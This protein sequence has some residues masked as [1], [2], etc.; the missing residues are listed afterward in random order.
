MPTTSLVILASLVAVS[1][2][3]ALWLIQY[4]QHKAIERARKSVIYT[5]AMRELHQAVEQTAC[6]I[7]NK[8][9][10]FCAQQ[11]ITLSGKLNQLGVSQNKVATQALQAAQQWNDNPALLKQK[12]QTEVSESNVTAM[13]AAMKVLI[14][15]VREAA[16]R[17]ECSVPAA[18]LLIR[19]LRSS[20]LRL[21]S[22][23]YIQKGDAA[24]KLSNHRLALMHYRKLKGILVKQKSLPEELQ[25]TLKQLDDLI[26]QA[27][28]EQK[29]QT[30]NNADKRLE[31][32]FDKM[33]EQDQDWEKKKQM[34]DD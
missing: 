22:Q 15:H 18:N 2:L 20:N 23:F 6:L 28:N 3:A 9:V 24:A 33:E 25:N 21:S 1:A 19:A 11:L 5:D 32:E 29:Q 30:D 31:A 34:Y 14:R 26:Q 4:R 7:D 13:R 27:Q 10:E 12:G 17:R 8:V 16:T